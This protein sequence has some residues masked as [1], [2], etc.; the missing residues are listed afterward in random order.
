VISHWLNDWLNDVPGSIFTC[1]LP[2]PM[3][4]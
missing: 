1:T 2:L 3:E 4:L